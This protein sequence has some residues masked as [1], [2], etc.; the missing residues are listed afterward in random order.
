MSTNSAITPEPA[1]G[2]SPDEFRQVRYVAPP[3]ATTILLVR[4]GASEPAHPDRPF[5][6]R[7]GHGDPALDPSGVR[8]SVQVGGR[9]ASERIDA[10]YVTS[11]RRTHQTAQPLAAALGLTPVELP[12]LREVHLGEWEGGLVRVKAAAL[13]PI[14]VRSRAEQRWDII[15]GAESHAAFT[16]R[17]RT[18]IELMVGA[19]PDG[20]IA[21]FVH[22]GVISHLLHLASGATPFGFVGAENGSISE[23]V[24]LGDDWMVRRFNDTAHLG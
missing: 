9:L 7:D 20:R 11:L 21:A 12:E 10:I 22:G 8:Q 24:I 23:L 13:D 15:P 18:G 14:W 2:Q 5:P 19:H 3:G 4:H 17:L 1:A 16:Q 6:L